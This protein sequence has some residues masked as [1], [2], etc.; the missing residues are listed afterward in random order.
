M[1]QRILLVYFRVVV[2]KLY[3]FMSVLEEG[4]YHA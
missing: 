4:K 3:G 2:K 1:P